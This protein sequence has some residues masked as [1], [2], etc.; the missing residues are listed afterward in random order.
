M[1]MKQLAVIAALSLLLPLAA[2]QT[3]ARRAKP[4]SASGSVQAALAK[5][6]D[7]YAEA[8]KKGDAVFFQTNLA[9]DYIGIE[10]DGHTSTKPE[11]LDLVRSGTI[12]IENLQVKTRS[13]RTYGMSAVVVSELIIRGTVGTT[14]LEGTYIST[15]VLEKTS[16]GQWESV[17]SQLTKVQ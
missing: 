4:K 3:A 1:N 16:N 15:R 11:V 12:K 5:L 8:A 17:L 2:G 10:A 6:I 9:R 13:V 7:E 14:E